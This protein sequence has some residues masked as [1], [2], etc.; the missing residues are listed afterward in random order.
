MKKLVLILCILFESVVLSYLLYLLIR[1]TR[2]IARQQQKLLQQENERAK[3]EE[4]IKNY[5]I[6]LDGQ[7]K[8]R[9]RLA[10]ELH[11]SL[12]GRL[13]AIELQLT[14][15]STGKNNTGEITGQLDAAMTELRQIA[16]NLTPET[17]LMRSGLA[18]ALR[19]YCYMLQQ[20]GAG[21]TFQ[22]FDISRDI[23]YPVQLMLYRI[24]QEALANAVKHAG[25]DTIIA[26]CS[27]HDQIIYITVE[28]NGK[29]FHPSNIP[30]N[31]GLESIRARVQ[32]LNGILD[33]QSAP[34][35]G[36]VINIECKLP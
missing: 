25:A 17:T 30:A 22:S 6:M 23:A 8:E 32:H 1:N 12:G 29:G 31:K 5:A 16:R 11:D 28:D 7:E 26:Q 4:Q 35:A 3:Q 18:E 10:R 33:I 34:G 13:S 36:T 19:D 2:R 15:A 24:V 14:D 27:Q 20:T 9:S 21:I